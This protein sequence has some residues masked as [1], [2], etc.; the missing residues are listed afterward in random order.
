[1]AIL[2]STLDQLRAR[3]EAALSFPPGSEGVVMSDTAAAIT[4][5]PRPAALPYLTV[6]DAR[7]DPREEPLHKC[8]VRR[9]PVV[10]AAPHDPVERPHRNLAIPCARI[11]AAHQTGIARVFG[12]HLDAVALNQPTDEPGLNEGL[13]VGRTWALEVE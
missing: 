2:Q 11:L 13:E 1:M 4:E 12:E 8:P 6:G 5:P 10:I 9:V 7:A 3:L